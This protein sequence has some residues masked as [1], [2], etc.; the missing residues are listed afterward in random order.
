MCEGVG[1]GR[2]SFQFP[3]ADAPWPWEQVLPPLRSNCPHV[4]VRRSHRQGNCGGSD[5]SIESKAS[6]ELVLFAKNCGR[7]KRQS[8]ET[9]KKD[10]RAN[11]VASPGQNNPG[12]RAGRNFPDTLLSTFTV[13]LL[14]E[15]DVTVTIIC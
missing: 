9:N 12:L 2:P 15:A 13:N 11:L 4:Q 14:H 3:S 10:R 7:R 5:T 8:S 1:K 6:S